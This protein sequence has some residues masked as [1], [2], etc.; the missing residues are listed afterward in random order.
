MVNNHAQ[1][2]SIKII[3]MYDLYMKDAK[4]DP[5]QLGATFIIIYI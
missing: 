4:R 3:L 5:I 1:I 2:G